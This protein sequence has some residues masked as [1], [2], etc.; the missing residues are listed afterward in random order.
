[1]TELLAGN[2]PL[3]ADFALRL[4]LFFDVPARWWL[5][6]QAR[7]EADDPARLAELR[8]VVTPYPGLADVLITPRGVIE[9]DD[10][11]AQPSPTKIPVSRDS[12]SRLRA[13]VDPAHRRASREPEVVYY[14]DGTP[15]LTG[16]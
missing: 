4:G 5:E 13:Q 3:T 9:L 11:P 15:V 12:L 6:M 14:E 16:R 7:Y 2:R 1:V 10:A 8:S